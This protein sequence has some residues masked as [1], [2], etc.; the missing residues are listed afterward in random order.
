MLLCLFHSVSVSSPLWGHLNPPSA[1]VSSCAKQKEPQF[2]SHGFR[3]ANPQHYEGW[4]LCQELRLQQEAGEHRLCLETRALSLS[5]GQ[6]A[7]IR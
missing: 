4:A 3:P 5:P 6:A 1:S 7:G 2:L